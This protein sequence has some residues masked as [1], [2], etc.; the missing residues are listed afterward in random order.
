MNFEDVRRMAMAFPGVEEHLSFGEPTLK[1][2]K[3]FLACVA[4]IDADSLCL[5]L[6]DALQRDFL[7]NS[8]PDIYYA[9]KHYADFGSILIR[10]SKA[11]PEE[12]RDLFEQAWRAYAPKRVVA[13]Y[14]KMD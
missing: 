1:V 4:K 14:Q 8:Q 12:V 10:M 5:K 13:A 3:R 7:V 2:G 11:D 9:P 6:P